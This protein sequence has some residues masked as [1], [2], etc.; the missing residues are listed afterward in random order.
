MTIDQ[1]AST[2]QALQDEVATLR[3]EADIRRIQARYMFL[4][5][6]PCPEFGVQDDAERIERILDLYTE[7][8]I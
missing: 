8:A 7:D 4:C 2:V 5:D 3:A 1:L 6:T